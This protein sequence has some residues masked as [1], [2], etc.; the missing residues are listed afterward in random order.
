MRGAGE[1]LGTLGSCWVGCHSKQKSVLRKMTGQGV[2]MPQS[3]ESARI[4]CIKESTVSCMFWKSTCHV[5]RLARRRALCTIS[6]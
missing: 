4:G 2:Q 5:I 1:K 6:H 3:G